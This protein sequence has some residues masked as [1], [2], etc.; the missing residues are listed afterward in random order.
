MR[1]LV[2]QANLDA[3][4]LARTRHAIDEPLPKREAGAELEVEVRR[5]L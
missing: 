4:K 2:V 3:K 1:V 5:G